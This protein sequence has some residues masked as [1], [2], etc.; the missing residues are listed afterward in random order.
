MRVDLF[1]IAHTQHGVFTRQQARDAGFSHYQIAN[2]IERGEWARVLGCTLRLSAT[3]LDPT[4]IAWAG[5]LAAGRDA[6]LAGPTAARRHGFARWAYP[7]WVTV[8][9]ERHLELP[10]VRLFREHID[11]EDIVMVHGMR[12]TGPARTVVD[13]LR[14]V[15][16]P[17]AR[18]LLDR[19]LARGWITPAELARRVS[20][21]AGRPGVVTLRGYLAHVAHQGKAERRHHGPGQASPRDA[22]AASCAVGL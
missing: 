6:V 19:A 7:T 20:G 2:R 8:P 12:V 16:A 15:R 5:Y 22:P 18:H 3:R 21:F 9:A 10:G 11:P 1:A 13:C 14:V 17:D 4:G